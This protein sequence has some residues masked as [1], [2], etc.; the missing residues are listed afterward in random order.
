EVQDND[1][2]PA[3]TLDC[4]FAARPVAD[5]DRGGT[6]GWRTISGRTPFAARGL[7]TVGSCVLAVLC[8]TIW[9]DSS[10]HAREYLSWFAWLATALPPFRR[11][12]G[13]NRLAS[14]R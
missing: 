2:R 11:Y 6:G 10:F 14:N 8:G 12:A 5:S 1:R 9:R 4:D 13:G 7:E 3:E